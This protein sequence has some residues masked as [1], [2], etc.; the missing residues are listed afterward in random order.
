VG[1]DE[2][3]LLTIV[4]AVQRGE[5]ALARMV[6]GNFV[7]SDRIGLIL[8]AVAVFAEALRRAS[9]ELPLRFAYPGNE[10]AMGGVIEEL[11]AED[12]A[13]ASAAPHTLH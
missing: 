1:G 4:T 5:G 6:A 9:V 7:P 13:A 12:F 2:V 10:P 8:G 3:A 11:T